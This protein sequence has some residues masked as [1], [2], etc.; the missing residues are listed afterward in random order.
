MIPMLT[1]TSTFRNASDYSHIPGVWDLS[2]DSSGNQVYFC[3][4]SDSGMKM[5]ASERVS[6]TCRL[7][8][9]L[10]GGS[11]W[12][13]TG[14]YPTS[15]GDW[16]DCCVSGDGST[17]YAVDYGYRCWKSIN[18]GLTWQE[19]QPKGN[20]NANWIN[21]TCNET[22]QIVWTMGDG[23]DC[24]ISINGGASWGLS[25]TLTQFRNV[26]SSSDGTKVLVCGNF[27]GRL[28]LGTQTSGAS[29]TWAEQTPAGSVDKP[30]SGVALNQNGSK[31]LA[32]AYVGRI[33]LYSSG[34]W[35]EVQ[36]DGNNDR[37]WYHVAI[38]KDGS[39]MMACA[40][41]ATGGLWTSSNGTV[42]TKNTAIGS[43]LP[44]GV[45]CNQD[46]SVQ[47][48]TNGDVYVNPSIALSSAVLPIP[49]GNLTD[50]GVGIWTLPLIGKTSKTFAYAGCPVI[51]AANGNKIKIY[52]NG[53]LLD[54]SLY[55]FNESNNFSG[56]GNI[57]TIVFTTDRSS[58][59]ITAQGLGKA[60]ASDST[61][62][63]EN[64]VNFVY[65]LLTVESDFDPSMF[66]PTK[67]S[68]ARQV[69][70]SQGYKAA[71]VIK[72]NRV[73][74][75]I[76]IEMMASFLG[77]AYKNGANLLCLDIDNGAIPQS[78]PPIISRSDVSWPLTDARQ[79]LFNLINQVPANYSYNYV[80]SS[81]LNIDDGTAHADLVSQGIYGVMT[82]NSAGDISAETSGSYDF[83]WCRDKAS[84]QIAQDVLVG[85]FA[86]PFYEIEFDDITL[87]NLGLDVGGFF[88]L[89][90]DSLFDSKGSPL[91]NQYW[92]M[93]SVKPDLS[94]KAIT[95]RANQTPYYKV[96]SGAR[97][98]MI[99]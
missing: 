89:T 94:K 38:S 5:I 74:W 62:L 24:Y 25:N 80:T 40:T 51:S 20:V 43:V 6:A 90:V 70:L 71:G 18:D 92:K 50:G 47:L 52:S 28:Y 49:Y 10:D 19:V 78:L 53:T 21:V 27:T 87:K 31:M 34:S 16:F 60:M 39:F 91:Y 85:K 1:D 17:Y 54:P 2:L 41:G 64:I 98:M 8:I 95:F 61:L 86:N 15:N 67:L 81:F 96:I 68:R 9:S 22:G 44:I 84:V 58:E 30:W 13:Q 11:N 76:I 14:P 36:P 32:C 97:D 4:V 77:S 23:G 65:D 3:G 66:E 75:D 46:G 88:I 79:R 48:A 82:P 7:W 33:Y 12:F 42:W 26:A 57:A 56:L 35:S 45:A 55:T 59:T 93:V 83:Y 37:S 73:F 99:Y 63:E 29:F 69:F 72:E